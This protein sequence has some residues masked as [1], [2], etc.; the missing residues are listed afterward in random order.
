MKRAYNDP[1]KT[2]Q[3][4]E[5]YCKAGPRY[6]SYPTA[7]HFHT[8]FTD[9]DWRAEL[10]AGSHGGRDLSLYVH[11][12]FCDT[13][14]WY[15]GC[16]MV[17]TRDYGRAERYLE[18]LFR[19]IDQ[20]SALVSPG[21]SV[22]QLHWGGGTPTFLHPDDMARLFGHLASRFSFAPEA[23]MGC[24]ADPREL[25][26]EHV[27]T[28]KACGFNRISLGVQ[29][30]DKKVQQAVHRVQPEPLIRRV[31]GWMREV[32]FESVNMDLM[33]G[34]PHQTAETFARTLDTVVAWRPD[35]LAVFN[36]AHVPWMKR[37]QKLIQESDLPDFSTRIALQE[38]ILDRLTAAG[39]VYIGMDHYALPGDELVLAQANKTLYRNF[40]GYTTHKD[41]DILAFGASAIS[42]TDDVYAQN[43]KSLRD[44]RARIESGRLATER[45]LRIGHDDKLRREAITRIMCDLELDKA[46]FGRDWGIDFD[47]HFDCAAEMAEM[48]TDG[49]VAL[50]GSVIR[51]T[52]TGRLF[53]RNIAMLFDAYYRKQVSSGEAP[54]YSKTV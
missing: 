6:T 35:R 49:L 26:R 39:Y 29:D 44:Y 23:E 31:Y 17:A 52:D 19:E 36:Y 4:L 11:I 22:K 25:T 10:E 47:V 5:K 53:L 34:L 18:L 42:Q 16:N 24:E 20:V 41:C 32:G 37:H 40:Q 54:R 46:A 28:L 8:Q 43:L 45:G 27:Q 30:L 48:A 1:M 33:A 13:L 14:C 3:L 12:P 2:A 15:C 38:L 9:A 7:P 21:R 50:E 51:V